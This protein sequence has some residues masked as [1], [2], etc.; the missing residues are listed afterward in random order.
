MATGLPVFAGAA[1]EM[2]WNRR[3]VLMAPSLF[4]LF[5]I[6]ATWGAGKPESFA[7]FMN[8]IHENAKL[9]RYGI[10]QTL[11]TLHQRGGNSQ[12][13]LSARSD[14]GPALEDTNADAPVS[15]EPR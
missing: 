10:S 8:Q 7:D 9:L 11:K 13:P 15:E 3:D 12:F 5:F 1:T 2:I 4:A 14:V 6:G